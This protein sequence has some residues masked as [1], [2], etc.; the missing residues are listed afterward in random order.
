MKND[1][2]RTPARPDLAAAFLQ[3]TVEAG[4]FVEGKI[5]GVIAPAAPVHREAST[6]SAMET[7]AIF[8]EAVTVYEE[9]DGWAWVQLARDSYVGW[10]E[11]SALG[12]LHPPTHRLSALRSFVYPR[13][14]IK[15][16]PLLALTFGSELGCQVSNGPFL[17]LEGGGFVF[18]KHAAPA[19][20]YET[21]PVSVAERFLGVP[22]LWGGK[23]SLGLDCSGLVQIALTACGIGCPRDSDMQEQQVGTRIE[24]APDLR[25]LRRGDL[26]FWKGHVAMVR[27]AATMIHATGHTMTVTLEDLHQGRARIAAA[28]DHLRTVRRIERP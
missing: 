4:R 28:G 12:S 6:S 23:T 20:F 13:P 27:D 17:A 22:Y 3:G 5:R 1:P 14:S 25:N 7:Q 2:R 15:D 18:G 11:A 10:V 9:R 21:D 19:D 26:L 16:P 8:G 24:P